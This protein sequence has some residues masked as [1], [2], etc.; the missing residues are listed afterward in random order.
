[1]KNDSE[2][3]KEII[4]RKLSTSVY[5]IEPVT[6]GLVHFVYKITTGKGIC[7]AKIRKSYFSALPNIPTKPEFIRYEKEAIDILS[8]I[9]PSLFP[10]L[11]AYIPNKHLLILSDIMPERTT[12]EMK[13]NARTIKKADAYNLGKILASVHKKLSYVKKKIR[14]NEDEEF[15][16]QLL[17]YRFGYHEHLILNELITNL[18]KLPRQPIL[19]DLSPKNIGVSYKGKFTFCD[20]ENFHNGNTISDVGFLGGSIIIHSIDNY[21]SAKNLLQSFF[22]GYS[23]VIK[24]EIEDQKLKKTVLGICLYRLE[25]LVIPYD[26]SISQKRKKDKASSIKKI[27][28]KNKISWNE[29]VKLVTYYN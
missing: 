24:L 26:I 12:L 16:N 11:L 21:P 8:K 22:D 1:M 29:L 27:L 9:E 20:F 28:Y 2:E 6:G 23:S 5:N 18:K 15:Y 10:K 7:F 19:G 4:E 14:E 13:L 25:N 17:F 3:L